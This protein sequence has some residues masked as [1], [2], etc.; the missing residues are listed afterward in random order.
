MKKT[1]KQ[2]IRVL[3]RVLVSSKPTNVNNAIDSMFRY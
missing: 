3:V 2:I 1:V